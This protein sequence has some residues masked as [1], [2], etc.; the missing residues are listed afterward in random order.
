MMPTMFPLK[1]GES[2]LSA[3][4]LRSA[5]RSCEA[6]Y[7]SWKECVIMLDPSSMCSLN[8]FT[9]VSSLVSCINDAAADLCRMV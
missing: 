1:A 9:R 5:E 8:I 6:Q 2:L 4:C 7:G 3:L